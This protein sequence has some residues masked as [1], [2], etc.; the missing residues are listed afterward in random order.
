MYKQNTYNYI[1]QD[2]NINSIEDYPFISSFR[3]YYYN[4]THSSSL[5]YY[6]H[7]CRRDTR[8]IIMYVIYVPNTA[9][10]KHTHTY[11]N[12]HITHTDTAYRE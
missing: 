11:N 5:R 1:K 7:Q 8:I 2:N 9:E 3:L 6:V 10:L 4:L 12:I